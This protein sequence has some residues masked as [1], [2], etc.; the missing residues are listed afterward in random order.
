MK[1]ELRVNDEDSALQS[2]SAMGAPRQL[3]EVGANDLAT[4]RPAGEEKHAPRQEETT[5]PPQ[6][7]ATLRKGGLSGERFGDYEL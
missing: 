7:G 5:T 2:L 1:G 3:E 6:V 4:V